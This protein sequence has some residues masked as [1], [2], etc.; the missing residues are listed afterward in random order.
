VLDLF[1]YSARKELQLMK[2][3]PIAVQHLTSH[4]SS[5]TT[6]LVLPAGQNKVLV[7]ELQKESVKKKSGKVKIRT[8]FKILVDF[9][10]DATNAVSWTSSYSCLYQRQGCL[11]DMTGMGHT[12][13][14]S[15]LKC[16]FS[17]AG[18][19]ATRAATDRRIPWSGR[20]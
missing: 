6:S 9:V 12:V 4:S 1:D 18:K 11:C 16:L 3:V 17:E 14:N 19:D 7:D 8:S 2:T 13:S 10:R 15:S 20:D 5:W